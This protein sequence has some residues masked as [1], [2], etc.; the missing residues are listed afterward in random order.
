MVSPIRR[1]FAL[2]V[3]I[4]LAPLAAAAQVRPMSAEVPETRSLAPRAGADAAVITWYG[5]LQ[6]LSGHLQQ[7][8]DR[9]LQDPALRQTRDRLMAA[10][11]RAMDAADA[12][13]PRLAQRVTQIQE[14]MAQAQRAGDLPRFQ[15]LEQERAR[16]QARFMRVRATVLRQPDIAR[17]SREYEDRLRARMI[18]IQPLTESLLARSRELQR[19]LQEALGER[20]PRN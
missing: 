5:E 12:E 19:L 20:Q 7:V 1:A 16:I 17:Q 2:A 13:L 15:T 14:E 11:Q 3:C 8:H 4:T 9:A 18:Q 6:S 10:V